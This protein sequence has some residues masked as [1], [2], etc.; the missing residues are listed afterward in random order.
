MPAPD[1]RVLF[2]ATPSPYLVLD[3]DLRIV[4]VNQA[5]LQATSTVYDQIIGREIFNVF[6]ENPDDP[7]ASGVPNLRAS[8]HRVLQTQCADT[9]A[10]QKYDIQVNS[11]EGV[12]F[13]ERYW[14][15]CDAMVAP[16]YLLQI[17]RR[18]IAITHD[19]FR[20]CSERGG[21]DASVSAIQAPAPHARAT[22]TA[23]ERCSPRRADSTRSAAAYPLRQWAS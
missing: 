20:L 17:R 12:R 2:D 18:S 9:M 8:L 19:M 16:P 14:V 15:V 5:Y 7:A 11:P 13:E 10:I 23:G 3:P 4:S 1:F 21:R 6:P 22:T